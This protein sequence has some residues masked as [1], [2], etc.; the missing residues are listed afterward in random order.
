MGLT[1]QRAKERA[2]DRI[3]FHFTRPALGLMQHP[4][5][6][7]ESQGFGFRAQT[8]HCV[9]VG[10][11]DNLLY[12]NLKA[13]RVQYTVSYTSRRRRRRCRRRLRPLKARVP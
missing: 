1:P 11:V 8:L 13:L 10:L 3:H 2:T 12:K 6:L 9:C 5:G 4:D 7:H